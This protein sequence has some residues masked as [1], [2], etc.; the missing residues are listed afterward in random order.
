MRRLQAMAWAAA[1]T[2]RRRASAQTYRAITTNGLE[3]GYCIMDNV[4]DNVGGIAGMDADLFGSFAEA[5]C[6]ALGLAASPHDLRSHWASQIYPVL[7]SSV[8]VVMGLMTL[9]L[10][11]SEQAGG[12]EKA[13]KGI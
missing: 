3:D 4:G 10:Q 1:S 8:G 12:V 5:T 6:V 2:P 9:F 13:L 7:I 11:K